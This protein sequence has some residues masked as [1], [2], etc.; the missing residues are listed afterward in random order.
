VEQRGDIVTKTRKGRSLTAK[1]LTELVVKFR[2]EVHRSQVMPIQEI[3]LLLQ[4][5]P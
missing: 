1:A 4:A 2:V 3:L 5:L